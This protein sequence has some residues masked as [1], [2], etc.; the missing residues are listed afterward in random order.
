MCC[1]GSGCPSWECEK[2]GCIWAWPYCIRPAGGF[3]SVSG[4]KCSWC[5]GDDDDDN[6]GPGPSC[7]WSSK[8]QISPG[9][10]TQANGL[11]GHYY[12]DNP[13]GGNRFDGGLYLERNDSRVNFDWGNGAP[14]S[15][16]CPDN[17]SANWTGY[18]NLPS[19]G[20]W[21]FGAT[22]DDGFAIDLEFTPG[23]WTRVFTDWSDHAAR[24]RWGSWRNINA[25][26][27]GIRVW[28]YEN[29][30]QAVARLRFQG[31]GVGAQIVPSANLRTCTSPCSATA[32]TN[33]SVTNLSSTSAQLNW[34]SGSGGDKQLLRLDES[35]SEVENG[36]PTGCLIKE[37]NL[38]KDLEV[39]NT[40]A[41]LSP[42]T[43]Y[44]WRV[45][46]W[47]S[48]SCWADFASTPSFT[49]PADPWV[50]VQGGDI[51]SNASVN[52]A[53]NVPDGEFNGEYIISARST[54]G[55]S[56]RSGEGW[57]CPLYPEGD[58]NPANN[59]GVT[60]PDYDT[61]LSR[62]GKN[63][64]TRAT[65]PP[66]GTL[67][68]NRVYRI[69]QSASING[70]YNVPV[71]V[72]ALIFIEGNLTIGGEIRVPST[73]TLTFIARDDIRISKQLAGGGPADDAIQ[74]GLI[75][76][77]DINTA[78][79]RTGPTETHRQLVTNG[80]LISLGGTVRLYRNLGDTDN[81][82]TP[83]ELINLDPKYFPLQRTL[84][85]RSRI[86]W[87]EVAP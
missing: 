19:S 80:P 28:F 40:E 51:H 75:A 1:K 52:F 30:G 36:C 86:F 62:F 12:R 26:W 10:C 27:Y 11:F 82:T 74:A 85:G 9:S 72:N 59:S 21:R 83:A 41:V 25:G 68:N 65:V 67:Q 71:G 13:V 8:S 3:C 31:P 73:S 5:S 18:I 70:V 55:G 66:G 84:M 48:A 50:K 56:V 7:N 32:P 58:L 79:D 60:A 46:E 17:F 47:K 16:L 64:I 38:D 15:N 53:R 39:Y 87:R 43:T 4:A 77:G 20:N 57:I 2:Q 14:D 33:P 78:Y 45:V 35:Q 63:P 61:L 44:Y 24:T 69:T 6:G 34:T 37:D 29:G 42:G 76:G 23:S 54:I 81:G 22:S 49:T